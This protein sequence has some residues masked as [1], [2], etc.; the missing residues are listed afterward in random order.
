MSFLD[1]L[2]ELRTRLVICIAAVAA[3]TIFAY[4]YTPDL[5]FP[6]ITAPL[7]SLQG[8]KSQN[9]FVIHA[10][11]WDYLLKRSGLENTTVQL[12]Y[13]S[14]NEPFMLRL[15][16]ACGGG[17]LLALPIIVYQIWAFVS[18]G[19]HKHERRL[20]VL[21]G[22]VSLLL[23]LTGSAI[24]YYFILPFGI[25][26]LVQQGQVFGL[27][28]VLMVNDYVPFVLWLL[29][30]FGVVFQMPLVLMFLAKLGIVT[31]R[32]LSQFRRYAVLIIFI[33]AAVLTPSADMF[34]QTAMALPMMGLYELSILLAR[35]AAKKVNSETE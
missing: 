15:K 31:P 21:F 2:V 7:D 3:A 1:H 24:A 9:P 27:T 10:A 23:F 11:F 14:L 33:V 32:S 5:L 26:F 20:V 18:A 4:F 22:P 25:I 28:P 17:V 29:L 30:G 6:F 13:S 34:T 8:S 35:I 19:L 12:N 16:I